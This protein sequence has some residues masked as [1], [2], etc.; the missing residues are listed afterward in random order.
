MSLGIGK[1]HVPNTGRAT[2]DF[3]SRMLTALGAGTAWFVDGTSGI[4]AHDG[5]TWNSAVKTI[6]HAVAL[7]AAGDTIFI[8]G[9]FTEAVT[10]SLAGLSIIGIGTGPQQAIWT[11]AADAK[12]LTISAE[13]VAVENIRFRPPAYTASRAT[14]AIYLTGANYARIRNCRF[15]GKTGSQA[16]I[17]G[18]EADSDNVLIENCEFLYLSTATYG[19][20]IRIE[21]TVDAY[22]SAWRILGCYFNGCV[23]AISLP[24]R[25]CL[26]KGNTIMDYSSPVAGGVP[27]V[28]MTLGINL[29]GKNASTMNGANSVVGNYLAGT[30]SE[31]LYKDATGDMWAGNFNIAGVTAANPAP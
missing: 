14:C 19:A 29:R 23:T 25:N 28:V 2:Q 8:K 10:C 4:D 22:C 3:M 17:H 30:Y 20:G 31:T 27:G 18:A 13:C 1:I 7:A 16:A 5:R 21:E 26:I 15:Q 24:A 6:A 11:G 12:C 9:S